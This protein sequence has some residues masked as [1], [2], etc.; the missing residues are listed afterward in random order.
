MF[1]SAQSGNIQSSPTQAQNASVWQQCPNW[2]WSSSVDTTSYIATSGQLPLT[3]AAANTAGV[4]TSD[5]ELLNVDNIQPSL[6][7]VPVNDANP[8]GWS[9]NHSVTLQLA[10]AT[11]PSGVSG[12]DCTDTVNAV[13]TPLTLT[14]DPTVSGDSDVTIDGNGSHTVSCSIANNAVDPQGAHDVGTSATTVD[15]DEQP[16]SLSFEAE[17]PASPAQVIVD[18]SDSESQV[19]G[20]TVQITRQGSSTAT[21]LPTNL[22]SNGQLTATV[23]DATLKAGTYT[24]QASA[25][26]QV[27]N[28]G[29]TT[30]TVT[31]PLRAKSDSAVSFAKI[32]DPRIAKKVRER[33]RVG[34]HYVTET[35]HGKAVKVKKGGHFKTITVIKRVEHC[36]TKRVKVAKHSWKLKTSCRA[37]HVSYSKRAIIRHGR[38]TKIYGE[39]TTG[40]GV[41]IANQTI[42]ILET[43]KNGGGKT[44]QIGTAS[45]NADGGWSAKIAAGPSRTIKGYYPGSATILPT[46]G[47]GQLFVPAKIKLRITPTK[48]PWG[49]VIK[50]RGKLVGGY[51]PEHGVAMR[52]LIQIPG[53]KKPFVGPSFRTTSKGTFDVSYVAPVVFD[54]PHTLPVAVDMVGAE[55]GYPYLPSRSGWVNVEFG[56]RTP[57]TP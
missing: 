46:S 54:Q 20:G 56:V 19:T 16:P 14:A 12:V 57:P 11:G 24:L 3:I 15:I 33:V 5:A 45:T 47:R 8:G 52:I 36:T 55:D 34:F 7:I 31:L 39:L 4:Q 49:S 32:I 6:S 27:G 44:R 43:P 21:T 13:A 30:E 37:A 42:E 26:S 9:V 40:Q 38:R 50:L 2:T 51:V 25:T 48:L 10:P 1:Y 17:N 29:T 28:T 53:L 35:K 23:P 22:T 41:A 18:S